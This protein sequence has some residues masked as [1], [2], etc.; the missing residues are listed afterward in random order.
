M[1]RAVLQKGPL[2]DLLAVLISAFSFHGSLPL[3]IFLHVFDEF[4]L[5]PANLWGILPRDYMGCKEAITKE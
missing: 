4:K 1:G 3:H 2:S 5:Q